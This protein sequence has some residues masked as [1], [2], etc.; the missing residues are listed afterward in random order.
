MS[1]LLLPLVDLPA[2]VHQ[3]GANVNLKR[4]CR[5]QTTLAAQGG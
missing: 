2:R 4:R 5:V 1:L 3:D